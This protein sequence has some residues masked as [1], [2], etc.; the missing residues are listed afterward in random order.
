MAVNLK[1]VKD[2]VNLAAGV[3]AA[4]AGVVD[5]AKQLG[6]DV[7]GAVKSAADGQSIFEG[8]STV[9]PL[10]EFI[11][12]QVKASEAAFNG[13][14][15]PGCYLI[16]TYRR[17]DH[18]KN[19]SDYLGIYVGSSERMADDIASIPTRLGDPDVY[20]D[21]KYRQNILL[22]VY[23]CELKD[24][25]ERRGLLLR[26]FDGERLYNGTGLSVER[27]ADEDL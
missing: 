13:Y 22:F 9:M 6:F 23:P 1:T 26:S 19:F 2:T 17:H 15:M 11:C 18:D 8:A 5:G 27:A 14:D 25:D 10:H 12:Q 20:A 7:D 16:A 21:Y 4:A 3:L 24:V